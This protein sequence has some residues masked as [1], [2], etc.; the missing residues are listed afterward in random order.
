MNRCAWAANVPDLYRDYHDQE[1][2]KPLRG[3]DELFE[4][5]CLEGFQAGLSWWSVLQRR[6]VLRQE[7]DDFKI[8]KLIDWD[9]ARVEQALVNPG[10]IRNRAKVKAVVTNARAASEFA[11]GE[12]TD[13]IWSFAGDS[14]VRYSVKDLPATT[15]ASEAMSKALRKRGFVFI[16][17]TTS[18]ALMQ[19]CGL[20]NDHVID[21]AFRDHTAF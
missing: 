19:A 9:E 6:D 12:L 7:F 4:R 13:L 8:A 14:P 15:P 1:W 18:Y 21:C 10:I 16:G 11:P 3:D 20:V 2:G 5:I 17:P